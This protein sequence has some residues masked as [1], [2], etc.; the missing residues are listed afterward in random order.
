MALTGSAARGDASRGSD[1]DLWVLGRHSDRRHL[2]VANTPVTLLRQTPRDALRFDSLCLFEVD[3][4]L[5][6]EDPRG[7][8]QRVRRAFSRQRGRIRRAIVK[9]TW[10]GIDA[11]LALARG[12]SGAQQLHV[13]RQVAFKAAALWL[14]LRTGWRVPRDRTLKAHLPPD[15]RRRYEVVLGLPAT[16]A[17]A[18]ATAQALGEAVAAARR[19]LA[20]QAR[21]GRP[22]RELPEPP[23]RE[24]A[25]RLRSRE[26]DEAL[27][28]ARRHLRLLLLPSVLGTLGARD[29]A[30]LG[31]WPALDPVARAFALAEQPT[32]RAVRRSLAALPGYVDALGAR[33]RAG[34]PRARR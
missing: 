24:L 1:L 4:L 14:F 20:V 32:P 29:V 9:A 23:S 16:P 17:R 22:V 5:V 33:L 34:T 28:L 25:A 27:L 8:F 19:F 11:D 26:W 2:V 6:L 18:R 10:D 13:L 12:A 21:A 31:A 15:V 3:D 7:H 30:S